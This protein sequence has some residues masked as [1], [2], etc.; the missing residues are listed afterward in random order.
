MADIATAA[1]LILC[2]KKD[3]ITLRLIE[4][5]AIKADG[6]KEVIARYRDRIRA[7]KPALVAYLSQCQD[8]APALRPVGD[9]TAAVATSATMGELPAAGANDGKCSLLPT[10]RVTAPLLFYQ[11]GNG[12]FL[13]DSGTAIHVFPSLFAA[14]SASLPPF[15]WSGLGE[16][17]AKKNLERGYR[18]AWIAG[19]LRGIHPDHLEQQ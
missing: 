11:P 3:G 9:Y 19:D 1:E 6:P 15:V 8:I 2:A 16:W 12:P 17:A 10:H 13:I 4:Q 14:K 18:L 7:A 5:N